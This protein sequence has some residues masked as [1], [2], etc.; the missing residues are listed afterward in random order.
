[1]SI[2]EQAVVHFGEKKQIRKMVEECIELSQ[3]L[4]HLPDGKSTQA[5]C[6]DEI[7]DVLIMAEQMKTIF[8]EENVRIA[9]DRKLK[10]LEGLLP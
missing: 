1:M 3:A 7:A 9:I 10:R 8:G 6:C 4:I 5:E 2:Y